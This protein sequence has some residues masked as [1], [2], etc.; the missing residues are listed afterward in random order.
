MTEQYILDDIAAMHD[1]LEGGAVSPEAEAVKVWW[2][3]VMKEVTGEAVVS[4][5]NW[6]QSHTGET[7]STLQ[8]TVKNGVVTGAWAPGAREVKAGATFATFSNEYGSSKRYYSG[9]RCLSA[10]RDTWVGYDSEVPNSSEGHRLTTV[11][12]YTTH[13][14]FE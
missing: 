9:M 13:R 4:L 12:I 3:N 2:L 11:V 5:K 1:W 8:V 7:V 14:R 10:D 6:L